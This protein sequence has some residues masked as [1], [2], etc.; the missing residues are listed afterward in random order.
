VEAISEPT[1]CGR[2][3]KPA[4]AGWRD[5]GRPETFIAEETMM[6]RTVRFEDRADAGRR[7]ARMLL[8]RGP[9]A[10]PVVLALPRGGVPVG[11]EIAQALDCPLDVLLVRKLG[12]PTQPELAMG[13]IATGD[14]RVLNAEVVYGA[15]VSDETIERVAARE[16]EELRRREQVYRGDRPPVDVRGR[17]VILVDDGVATGSTLEAGIQA[18]RQR[19]PSTVILAI[20]T[21]PGD[22]VERLARHADEVLCLTSPVPFYA[23]SLSYK[24]FHQMSDREVTRLIDAASVKPDGTPPA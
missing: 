19:H 4:I 6:K 2:A 16:S 5:G 14:V 21:A 20:P 12:L 3:G 8:E 15:G 9:I 11:Y 23:I 10:D 22:V 13:A 7:L 24:D 18:L 1:S 17:T